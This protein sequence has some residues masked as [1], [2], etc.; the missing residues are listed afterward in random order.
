M[1]VKGNQPSAQ[2]A[3][4]TNVPDPGTLRWTDLD[5]GQPVSRTIVVR[6]LEAETGGSPF[7]AQVVRLRCTRV[8]QQPKAVDLITSRPRTALPQ[9]P[10]LEATIQHGGIETDLARAA[11]SLAPRRPLPPAR[12]PRRAPARRLHP[13]GQQPVHPLAPATAQRAPPQHHRPPGPLRRRGTTAARFAPS[14]PS[15]SVRE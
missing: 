4:Q 11:R 13:L 10:S 5:K 9:A 8:G 12:T 2:T 7:V 14:P 1:S 15:G 3:V 6:S